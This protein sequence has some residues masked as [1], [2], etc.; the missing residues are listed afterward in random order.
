[1]SGVDEIREQVLSALVNLGYP[2]A[3]ADKVVEATAKELAPE[4]PIEAWI[5]VALRR[6]AR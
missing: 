3:Q 1:M 6:L 4:E 2:K 5:R